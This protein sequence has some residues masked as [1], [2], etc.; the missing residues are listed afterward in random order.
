M[1]MYFKG[2]IMEQEEFIKFMIVGAVGTVV[3]LGL[4]FILTEYFDLFYL[5]SSAIA[6]ETSIISNFIFNDVWTFKQD[7]E[8][9]F[10]KRALYYQVISL[11][12]LAIQLIVVFILTDSFNIYYVLSGFIGIGVSFMLNFILNKYI[13]FRRR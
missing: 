5:V 8:K 2:F 11:C 6:I 9:R 4:L 12:S 3:N 1:N 13:T 7:K 10:I